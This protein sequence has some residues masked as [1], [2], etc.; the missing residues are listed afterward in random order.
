MDWGKEEGKR[1]RSRLGGE[2]MLIDG[3]DEL[4][5]RGREGEGHE[6]R[7]GGREE[8]GR[9]GRGK[10]EGKKRTKWMGMRKENGGREWKE[11]Q[12]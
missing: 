12:R 10:E 2:D 9:V 5:K 7:E 6:K 4:V 8:A 1:W 11:G 3:R